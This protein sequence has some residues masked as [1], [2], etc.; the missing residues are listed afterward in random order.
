[1]GLFAAHDLRAGERITTY[2]GKLVSDDTVRSWSHAKTSHANTACLCAD[3]LCSHVRT[4][5]SARRRGPAGWLFHRCLHVDGRRRKP[6]TDGEIQTVTVQCQMEMDR[7]WTSG[8]DVGLAAYANDGQGPVRHGGGSRPTPSPAGG[9]EQRRTS[10]RLQPDG[11]P[12]AARVCSG[13]HQAHPR[14][15]RNHGRV[16]PVLLPGVHRTVGAVAGDGVGR[17]LRARMPTQTHC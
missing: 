9:T 7:N 17:C 13:R 2:H 12:T 3:G 5:R 4:L 14:P 6:P 16:R 11:R 15:Q 8:V 1:M 10:E